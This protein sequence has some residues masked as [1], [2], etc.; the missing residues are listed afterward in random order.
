MKEL[1]LWFCSI[2]FPNRKAYVGKYLLANFQ[3]NIF[4]SYDSKNDWTILIRSSTKENGA[5]AAKSQKN[6]VLLCPGKSTKT[7]ASRPNKFGP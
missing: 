2:N 3:R 7:L 1:F 5:E 6:T 4:G